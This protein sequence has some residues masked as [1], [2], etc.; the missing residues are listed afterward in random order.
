VKKCFL[1]VVFIFLIVV[2]GWG[3]GFAISFPDPST[4]IIIPGYSPVPVAIPY[5]DF[6]S[7]SLPI[8]AYWDEYGK[9]NG[10]SSPYHVDSTPGQIKDDIV[11]A[12]GASGDGVET[13]FTGMDDA[14]AT[15]SGQNGSPLFSTAYK[16]GIP[17][18]D[19]YPDPP[20]PDTTGPVNKRRGPFTGDADDTWD[21]QIGALLDY[22]TPDTPGAERCDLV[23]YFN[24]NQENS[25]AASNQNLYAWGQA[26][27]VDANYPV[28][29]TPLPAMYFDLTNNN[30]GPLAYMNTL[31][32]ANSNAPYTPRS[33]S[34][35]NDG[36]A[37]PF[38]NDFILSGGQVNAF[39]Q[40]FNHNLG[41]DKA[42]YAIY[43]PEINGNLEAWQT[44]GYDTIQ[45][46]LR[47]YD[48]NNGYEQAFILCSTVASPPPPPI[49]EP[50]TMVL[51][52]SGLIGAAALGRKRFGK[53]NT[54][55]T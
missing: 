35:P 47:F 30:S 44:Q 24:N 39:G 45:I 6:Y 55:I 52:G 20:P 46:D 34:W 18:Y 17:G 49:P 53:K 36:T 41:A 28:G 10:Y 19:G 33:G 12:T 25:G 31:G 37:S 22:L 7:Y 27:I 50:T 48:L 1:S 5:G 42:A 23:F 3:E 38:N 11:I 9:P 32:A 16:G 4:L 26:R 29:T 2:V 43:S 15:P 40:T 8:L 54:N 21:M 51:V 14:Y 13:N